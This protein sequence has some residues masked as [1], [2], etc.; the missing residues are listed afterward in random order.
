MAWFAGNIGCDH[1]HHLNHR[2]P[3]YRLPEHYRDIP[4]LRYAR[5]TSLLPLEI[6]RCLCLKV[7]KHK[8]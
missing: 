8:K 5:A 4:E 7:W 3:P 2:V 6:L 1:I